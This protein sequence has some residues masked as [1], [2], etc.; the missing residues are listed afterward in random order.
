M[1]A[2]GALRVVLVAESALPY[3]SGVTIATDALARGLTRAGHRVLLLAPRPN[4]PS[5]PIAAAVAGPDYARHWLAS[6][7][8]PRP[9]PH[10]YRLPWPL[11]PR[12]LRAAAAFGPQIV[13][14]QSPFIAGRLARRIAR[15]AAAPLVFTHHTR[16]TDYRH[17]LGPLA[18]GPLGRAT[19]ALLEG[20]LRRFWLDCDAIVAPSDDLAAE[21]ER[22]VGSGGGPVV[23]AIPSGVDVP[24]IAALDPID[25]RSRAGW[26]PEAIVA[27]SHGRLA[28]EKSVELLLEAMRLVASRVPRLRLLLVGGGPSL[29]A[30]RS[31]AAR[32]G[33]GERVHFSGPLPRDEALRLVRGSDL[34]AFASRTEAQG[35][36][37]AEALAAGLP[38][39]ALDGPA[40][41]DSVRDGVDGIVVA[42]EPD[43]ER[44]ERL[45]EALASLAADDRRRDRLAAAAAEGA[46]RFDVAATT[47]EMVEL[48]RELPPGPQSRRP[49]RQ[50]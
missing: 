49:R 7:Q 43:G 20:Y 3:L 36:V 42:A 29:P 16:F 27:V 48:Y 15:R 37:L 2:P 26:P 21:I 40:I 22:R 28:A 19:A 4:D 38:V 11:Q 10:G 35:L 5:A 24:G 46:G 30:L 50:R 23:R 13:H 44:A 12:A 32:A 25:P 39:V 33:I 8:P 47:A 14:A 34:F 45:A 31:H 6:Y 9:V 18:V 17:Y 41:R 1:T